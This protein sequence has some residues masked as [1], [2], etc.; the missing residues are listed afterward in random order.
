MPIRYLTAYDR[1]EIRHDDSATRRCLVVH[2][3][4]PSVQTPKFVIFK[5]F[6]VNQIS[7]HGSPN[8]M[9]ILR[10]NDNKEEDYEKVTL[11]A[12]RNCDLK[13]G[14]KY[15]VLL[16]MPQ[17]WNTCLKFIFYIWE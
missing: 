16:E 8:Y 12:A 14:K 7:Q 1:G 5:N 2:G 4:R 9:R 15:A 6:T 13:T 10:F 3:F 17:S 11:R